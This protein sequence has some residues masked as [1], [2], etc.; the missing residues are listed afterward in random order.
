MPLYDAFISYS[1]AKDKPIAAALQSVVQ[2]LGKPWAAARA[3]D[4]DSRKG[5]LCE[6]DFYLG[7]YQVEK[8]VPDEAR[9]LF[10]SAIDRCPHNFMEYTV[11]Q[12][13]LRRLDKLAGGPK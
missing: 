8:E 7:M 10:Q 9:R 5:Q 6:A 11:A 3:D 2:R 12:Q 1:H 4:D 13:E